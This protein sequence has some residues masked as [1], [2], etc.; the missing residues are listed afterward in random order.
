LTA[1]CSFTVCSSDVL[2]A[3]NNPE[4]WPHFL[5]QK[6]DIDSFANLAMSS[7]GNGAMANNLIYFLE[8]KRHWTPENTLVG[9][10][11]TELDRLD[12]RCPLG[13]PDANQ[14]FSW[15]QDLGHS[16]LTT[17]GFTFSPPPFK[18]LLKKNQGYEQI[19][20]QNCLE[21]T[22]LFAYL[23]LHK[24]PYF[25]MLIDNDVNGDSPDW[26]KRV[27]EDHQQH[28][29]KP[30]GYIGMSEYVGSIGQCLPDGWHPNTDGH[31]KIADEVFAFLGKQ[32]LT[33]NIT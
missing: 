27:L 2:A 4:S 19:V 6:L 29:V 13:H 30:G 23:D 7:G 16:W 10:S 11:I 24:F 25:F 12:I 28:R 20:D 26:F 8:T 5:I 32:N 17:N 18:D 21:V 31:S 15:D 33:G 9:F 22:K 1:G 3:R 14:T